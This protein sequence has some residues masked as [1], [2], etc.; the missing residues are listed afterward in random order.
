MFV[1]TGE[2]AYI[3]L[4]K[5]QV[6]CLNVLPMIPDGPRFT[7][8]QTYKPGIWS[9]LSLAWTTLPSLRDQSAQNNHVVD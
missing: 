2:P 9:L 6:I 8:P 3:E 7:Q 1:Q 4:K 5:T